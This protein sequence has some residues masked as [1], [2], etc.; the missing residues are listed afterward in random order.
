[1]Q[2]NAQILEQT[3]QLCRLDIYKDCDNARGRFFAPFSSSAN[4]LNVGYQNWDACSMYI[5]RAIMNMSIQTLGKGNQ[6]Q[7]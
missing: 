6:V 3:S 7:D 2:E 1:M 5:R 4:N